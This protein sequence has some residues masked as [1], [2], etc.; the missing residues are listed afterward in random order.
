MAISWLRQELGFCFPR[1][2]LAYSDIVSLKPWT[3][4][5]IQGCPHCCTLPR[6][7]SRQLHRGWRD[8]IDQQAAQAKAKIIAPA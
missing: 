4:P 1:A 6:N 2:E 8:H 3:Y 5:E 7:A